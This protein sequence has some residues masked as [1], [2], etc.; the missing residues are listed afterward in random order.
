[1]EATLLLLFAWSR[2]VEVDNIPRCRR[3]RVCLRVESDTLVRQVITL[4]EHAFLK[5][6]IAVKI[7]LSNY[8]KETRIITYFDFFRVDKYS[9]TEKSC[10]ARA[11]YNPKFVLSSRDMLYYTT[12]T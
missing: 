7:Y 11:L 10:A 9:F 12:L 3:T 6:C 8:R 2:M 5:R 1:M 4:Q